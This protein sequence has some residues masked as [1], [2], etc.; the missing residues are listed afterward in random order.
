MTY[1]I[2]FQTDFFSERENLKINRVCHGFYFLY[3]LHLLQ[4]TIHLMWTDLPDAVMF[5]FV[6]H[7]LDFFLL[8][9]GNYKIDESAHETNQD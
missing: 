7:Y 2:N 6:G 5:F 9:P 1:S 3:K 4:K 8:F